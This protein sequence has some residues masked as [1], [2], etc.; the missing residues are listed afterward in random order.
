MIPFGK[1]YGIIPSLPLKIP[2]EQFNKMQEYIINNE[3]IN[4]YINYFEGLEFDDG[5]DIVLSI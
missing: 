1:Y 4:N 5:R 3:D 2:N